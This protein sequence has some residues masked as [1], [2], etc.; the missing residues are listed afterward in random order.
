MAQNFVA[1]ALAGLVVAGI[2]A[3][4]VSVL[5]GP[6]LSPSPDVAVVPAAGTPPPAAAP[7]AL[8]RAGT[9]DG[10]S[11]QAASPG[12]PEPDSGAEEARG[13][14]DTAS[15]G[16]SETGDVADLGP[17]P[18]GEGAGEVVAR[19][20][21]PVQPGTPGT[22]PA[23]PE[24]D[25]LS[26]S[27]NPAQPAAPAV[28][29]A[30]PRLGSAEPEAG[31]GPVAPEAEAPVGASEADPARA[32]AEAEADGSI[33]P[34]A[35][36]AAP[37]AA[38]DTPMTAAAPDSTDLPAPPAAEPEAPQT[39]AAPQAPGGEQARPSPVVVPEEPPAVIALAPEPAVTEDLAP[40][41][42]AAEEAV[43]DS[44]PARPQV[45][46]LIERDAGEDG[47][48]D[49]GTP[50]TTLTDRATG[51]IVG[52][53][54]TL[55]TPPETGAAAAPRRPVEAFAVPAEVDSD[56]PLMSI[57]LID[58]GSTPM[59]LE[60]LEAFP[61][62]I[63]F[64]VDTAWQGAAEAMRR[65]RDAGFEVM[66]LANL[67]AGA[68]PQDAEI[69][70]GSALSAVPEAVAVLE[71]DAGGLQESREVSDQVARILADSGHG[72]VLYPQ[73]L[74]TGQAIAAR[75]G[76]PAATL[77]RDFD[78]KGQT[79]TVIRRFLDQA[80]FKAGQEGSV[81]MLGRLRPETISALLIW[82]LQDRASRVA[83]VPVTRV[84]LPEGAD[85]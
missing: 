44:R 73:G 65:Y 33:A 49:I 30:A 28:T 54:P 46:S 51:V 72:L 47:R 42:P 19:G 16:R 27:N 9:G 7:D 82:G 61:Y 3:G 50:A 40:V 14:A 5:M 68:R 84:L 2:G 8:P 74:N 10:S 78:S 76:V 64:A 53:L 45:S 22:P 52:R 71:G 26:I 67:P 29:E 79:A 35:P 56:K 55:D 18:D 23:R 11:P 1:G 36:A 32:R 4:T 12:I 80:A 38:D 77:F 34:G 39:A 59:G 6:V 81:I 37:E 57:V 25:E 15:T 83:F 17:G 21:S 48:P 20:V 31:A 43:R 62:P 70:L 69:S 13:L 24:A 60:A 85:S 41:A 66:A 58:D 75:A 63:T